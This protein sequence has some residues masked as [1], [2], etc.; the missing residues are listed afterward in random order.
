MTRRWLHLPALV[1][2]GLIG[3][4]IYGLAFSS[5]GAGTF[6][7]TEPP[8]KNRTWRKQI[9]LAAVAW[10]YALATACVDDLLVRRRIPGPA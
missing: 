1:E 7:A 6:T 5:H 8:P 9:S 10:T 2:G 3:G 4:L